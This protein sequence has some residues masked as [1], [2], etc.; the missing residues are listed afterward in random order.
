[1]P[2]VLRWLGIGLAVGFLVPS[3]VLDPDRP[4]PITTPTP[5]ARATVVPTSTGWAGTIAPTS[6]AVDGTSVETVD[7]P[8]SGVA[9]GLR[10][11]PLDRSSRGEVERSE[12]VETS[13][14]VA[15]IDPSRADTILWAHNDSG[16]APGVFAVDLDGRDRGF[17]ALSG[18]GAP[19]E[20]ADL[21]DVALVDGVLY[22]ADIGDN[23]TARPSVTIYLA[24]EPIPSASGGEGTVEVSSQIEVVYPDGPTDAEAVVVDPLSGDLLILSK[25]LGHPTDPTRLYVVDADEMEDAATTG[26]NVVA[27]RAGSLDVVALTEASSAV[28][29]GSV[30][31]PGAVTA[32]DISVD[33]TIIAVRTYASVWLFDRH[34]DQTMVEALAGPP[35]E[36]G[37][38]AEGQGE[39]LALLPTAPGQSHVVY[40]TISEGANRPVNVVT[41]EIDR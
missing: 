4:D 41:V 24:T 22:L 16:Q 35:C 39:A 29:L 40:A 6:T 26:L 18:S 30:L 1:M 17:F 3:C 36:G 19:V 37:A 33:G 10:C 28:A 31:F 12:L 27:R 5:Q 8:W 15:S 11:R 25:D 14:L 20:A 2:A 7:S 23:D 38:V 21:E 9:G 34:P 13:G 32:A